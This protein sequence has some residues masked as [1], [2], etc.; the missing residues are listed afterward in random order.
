MT[1]L[2]E[3]KIVKEIQ[4]TSSKNYLFICKAL[5]ELQ[6][7][8][9]TVKLFESSTT[10]DGCSG[11]FDD[12]KKLL[13]ISTERPCKSFVEIFAHEYCHYIQWKNNTKI[14]QSSFTAIDYLDPFY[15]GKNVSKSIRAIQRLERDCERRVLK[16]I[17]KN[18]VELNY[19]DY[20]RGAN[21]Y[22]AFHDIIELTRSWYKNP[23]L[24]SDAL[25][26]LVPG[27]K[28]IKDINCLGP[29]KHKFI[30]ECI[31]KVY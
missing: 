17:E 6:N 5:K 24:H 22:I 29:L 14:W 1:D 20:V 4:K 10:D 7:S 23:S 31:K 11:Y 9:I 19:E 25:R 30:V 3:A 27:N 2:L 16:L 28:L 13:A 18:I 21:C 12:E 8:S 15:H 26:G